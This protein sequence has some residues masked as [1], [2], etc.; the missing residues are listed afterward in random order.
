MNGLLLISEPL[1]NG[2]Q[3]ILEFPVALVYIKTVSETKFV[4]LKK[5]EI[6]WVK[7]VN[8]DICKFQPSII[9]IGYIPSIGQNI[10]LKITGKH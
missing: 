1:F 8:I 4:Q 5:N 2:R 10:F 3:I 6:F 7:N 9:L